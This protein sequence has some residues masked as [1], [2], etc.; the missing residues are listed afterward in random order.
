MVSPTASAQGITA[1][2]RPTVIG[3]PEPD[4]STLPRSLVPIASP[5][6]PKAETKPT[7]HQAT[8]ELESWGWHQNSLRHRLPP[9]VTDADLAQTAEVQTPEAPAHHGE[10]QDIQPLGDPELGVIRVRNPLEDPE[11][12]ILRVREQPAPADHIGFLTARFSVV[13]SDNVLL[14]VN[15]VG[16]LTGDTFYRPAATL[17]VY[18]RL[19]PETVLIGGLDLGLQRYGQQSNIDYNDWRARVALRQGL[20]PRSYAQIGVT[21]QELWRAGGSGFRFFDNRAVAFSLGRRDP[22]S[23]RLTLESFYQVQWNEARAR[24]QT[25]SGIVTTDFSRL[26]QSAG[27]YL[28]YTLSPQWHTGLNYQLNFID[29]STQDRY[30]TV[31]QLLGQVVYS[32]TPQVRISL[33]GG[34]SFGRSSDPSIRLN[35]ALFGVTLDATVP[36]F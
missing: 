4:V 6:V 12:G 5:A 3:H 32:I 10:D 23:P 36:L 1:Q 25:A 11:L 35:D 13:N 22:L 27:A 24:S 2:G 33:Y 26:S 9:V 29:Y 15:D 19:G 21:Y 20:S 28:G 31:Q 7:H 16:G 14:L 30:D 34:W 8:G 17:A 18:P